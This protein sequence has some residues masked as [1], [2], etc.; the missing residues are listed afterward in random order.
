[1]PGATTVSSPQ[2]SDRWIATF[3]RLSV[4]A[5]FLTVLI[6]ALVL[7]GWEF[8]I[9]ILTRVVSESPPMRPNTAVALIL[10]G[11]ALLL[12]QRPDTI[13]MRLGQAC[14]LVVAA[15]GL[16]TVTEYATG[17]D[18]GIDNPLSAV[19]PISRALP[20][21]ALDTSLSIVGIGL[22]LLLVDT[23]IDRQFYPAHLLSLSVLVFSSLALLGYLYGIPILFDFASLH[24]MPLH[25]TIGFVIMS[26]GILFVR[27]DHGF[28]ALFCSD[29]PGGILARRL[30]LGG[31]AI[32]F[33]LD[34]L[35]FRGVEAGWYS[36]ALESV[37]HVML[38]SILLGALILITSS[39]LEQIDLRRKQTEDERAQ[40]LQ[41]LEVT[42][43]ELEAFS[44][45]V[46]HDLRTPLAAMK[47]LVKLAL[48]EHAGTLSPEASRILNLAYRN[49][50]EMDLLIQ[51]LLSFSSETR[52]PLNKQALDPARVAQDV[53]AE[54]EKERSGRR[55]EFQLDPMP[56]CL[57]DP[58]LL[59]QVY[60][61]L[62]ANAMK[63]TRA[64]PTA[65]IHVGAQQQDQE[66]AY[67]VRDNGVGFDPAQAQ[68]LFGV[69]QRLHS[70][71][72]YEGTGVGL[73]IV[74]R[75][76]HRHGGHVWA[77][78]NV[79]KGA[80][81]YFTLGAGDARVVAPGSRSS[82]P[83]ADEA[84]EAGARHDL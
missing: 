4:G 66:T 50:S 28:M 21:M 37:I 35:G 61:N 18:F 22:A 11:I 74:Q 12:I 62:I 16:V 32:P 19:L 5:S 1:M 27:P 30:L 41:K 31:I 3:K 24:G 60:R 47:N 57:A 65:R 63:F 51:G 42:N 83:S 17:Q 55:I 82:R 34:W 58:V 8:G 81:F 54:M 36:P 79:D 9:Q 45:S 67:F 33:L 48:D 70:E 25:T 78:G 6:G 59:K 26:L 14:A 43:R 76:I 44:Y 39:G 73:A 15:I 53:F 69:F 46:S 64:R 84:K 75:I 38:V 40:A 2:V 77:E 49:A 68:Q 7:F 23:V 10:S 29:G 20:P 72:E 52:R 56:P 13:R 71:D 80:T